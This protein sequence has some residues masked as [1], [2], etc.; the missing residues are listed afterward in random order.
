MEAVIQWVKNIVYY[1]IF[2]SLV[3]NLLPKGKYEQYIRLFS[4]AVF[5]LI[6]LAPLT[7][8]LKL[9]NS[10]PLPMNGFSSGRMP[11][12]LRRSFGGLRTGR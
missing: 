8:G 4:G 10:W 3:F 6:A 5:L 2:I 1:L 12:S 11:G 7:G 9:M